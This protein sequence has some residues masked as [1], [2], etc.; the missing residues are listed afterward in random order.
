ML[1]IK[2]AP[3]DSQ[4]MAQDGYS[5]LRSLQNKSLPMVDL[6]VRESIQN[7]L[8]ATI[9]GQ[10]IRYTLVD[11][12]V[13]DFDSRE[14]SSLFELVGS[15]INQRCPGKQKF[16][17]IGD[18]NTTGL[19]GAYDSEDVE[20]LNDSNFHKLVFGIGKN[21][22]K[23]GAGGSWGLGKTSYFRAGI[24]LVVY[25]TRV[26]QDG[27]YEERLIAS[28]IE[29]NK[30]EDRLLIE[31]NR[32]IAWWGSPSNTSDRILPITDTH[33]IAEI[34]SIFGLEQYQGKETG[35]QIIIP[36]LKDEFVAH[37]YQNDEAK[38]NCPWLN[39]LSSEI[40]VAVQ[41]WYFP[42]INNTV[43]RLEYKAS[44][45]ICKVNG[46]AIFRDD[47]LPTFKLF[48]DVYKAALIGNSAS[49]NI[50]VKEIFVKRKSLVN[51]KE[52]IGHVAFMEASKED[53]EMT[54][55]E[56]YQSPL[57]YLGV[58]NDDKIQKEDKI[59]K[60][61][62]RM[63]GFSRRPGMIVRYDVDGAWVPP[64]P[65]QREGNVLI[66]MFVPRSVAKL[67]PKYYPEYENMEQYLRGSE[68]ADHADWDDDAGKSLI[69]RMIANSRKAIQEHFEQENARNGFAATSRLAKKYGTLLMPRTGFGKKSSL[70][71]KPSDK[72]KKNGGGTG[73]RPTFTLVG[74]ELAN[75][76]L[77]YLDIDM[78]IPTNK[79]CSLKI[80][81]L[82]Q[83]GNLD[84]MA[85]QRDI[86]EASFPFK[87]VE[88][89]FENDAEINYELVNGQSAIQF[90][91]AESPQ[92]F[93][94]KI[95]LRVKSNKFMPN[96]MIESR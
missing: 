95:G 41:R 81:V 20:V 77:V 60:H 78:L 50:T 75:D 49:D 35:T 42:R 61:N 72:P 89:D 16:L 96:I 51:P 85:W 19:T 68:N 58:Y 82:S 10:D 56:Y 23:E 14:F 31:S 71:K 88:V 33:K 8:D 93:K 54:A 55:P 45:L 66:A 67:D 87:I 36:F 34:L 21:Q 12:T 79:I 57:D 73:E 90:L 52:P 15:K 84:F 64:M 17:A 69:K 1:N 22:D 76:E 43:Y 7:S 24:G 27:E 44:E 63:L 86:S 40:E 65:V 92:V 25:Y 32:G 4:S 47:L 62:S 48:Q 18:K 91:P 38:K 59:Q 28:L 29:D 37:D 9:T 83:G 94:M 70:T 80:A 30:Q 5:I 2:L 3:E 13:G 46:K 6:L 53:L 74:T 11:Y 26:F 39:E